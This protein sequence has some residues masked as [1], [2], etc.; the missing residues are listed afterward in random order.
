MS[1]ARIK[2]IRKNLELTQK[3]FAAM[4]RKSPSAVKR[5]EAGKHP[6]DETTATLL[7]MLLKG[8]G[9]VPTVPRVRNSRIFV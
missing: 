3:Q 6:M 1:P 7:T 2:T 5:W 4:L 9:Y 8:G